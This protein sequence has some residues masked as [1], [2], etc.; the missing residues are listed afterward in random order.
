MTWRPLDPRAAPNLVDAR[1]Q[2]HHAAQLATALGIA[3]LLHEPDDSHTN[4][5]WIAEIGALASRP[6]MGSSLMRVAV[7]FHPFAV[8]VLDERNAARSTL[9]LQG[10]TIAQAA[11]WIRARIAEAGLDASLYTLDKHYTIPSH[12]VAGSGI[13]DAS[14]AAAFENLARFY[15][16]AAMVLE[17]IAAAAPNSD[18]VR[19]WPHH[20]DIAAL[21]EVSPELATAPRKTISLGMEPGDDYYREPYFYA[22]MYP[23]PS[24]DIERPPLEGNGEWHTRDWLGAVLPGSRLTTSTQQTQVEAFLSSAVKACT[25]L[26]NGTVR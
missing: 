6:V 22:S 9:P 3:Y 25:S 26:L 18:P 12:P 11:A 5:E 15:S 14:N 20:F 24:T 16:D 1:L 2:V 10:E 19:C 17:E 7:Q 8:L 23:S 13:F 4:L 21:L